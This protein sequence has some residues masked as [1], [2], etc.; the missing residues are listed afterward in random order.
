[1]LVT[2]KSLISGIVRSKEIPVDPETLRRW[3]AG[4]GMI[5][6]LMPHLTAMEREFIMTG[7]TEDE[8]DE[9]FRED[10]DE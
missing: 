8:W 1:M 4:G 6:E 7:V 5:Q 10:E 2:R 9:T 3:E